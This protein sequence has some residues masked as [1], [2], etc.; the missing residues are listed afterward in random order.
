MVWVASLAHSLRHL[1]CKSAGVDGLEAEGIAEADGVVG[2][3]G[4]ESEGAVKVELLMGGRLV[5]RAEVD[6]VLWAAALGK[7]AGVFDVGVPGRE[8]LAVEVDAGLAG[9]I[10]AA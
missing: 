8:D 6:D 10:S 2:G 5:C 1:R 7:G 9:Q 4:R 3:C